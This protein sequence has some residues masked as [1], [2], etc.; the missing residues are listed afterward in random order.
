MGPQHRVLQAAKR[1]QRSGNPWGRIVLQ[2]PHHTVL[3]FTLFCIGIFGGG[4]YTCGNAIINFILQG[5]SGK[6]N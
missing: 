3:G 5:F 6:V 4:D 1:Q 2:E